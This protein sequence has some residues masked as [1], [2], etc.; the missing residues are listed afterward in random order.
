ML[1]DPCSQA[2]H[3]ASTCANHSVPMIARAC[4]CGCASIA[5]DPAPYWT[6]VSAT[7]DEK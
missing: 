1:C 7:K 4:A 3:D 6:H 5:T 2:G